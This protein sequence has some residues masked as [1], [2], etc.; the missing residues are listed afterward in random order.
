M[1][2]IK[3]I[4]YSVFRGVRYTL[5]YDYQDLRFVAGKKNLL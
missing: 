5:P 4:A 3:L 1:K 2:Y